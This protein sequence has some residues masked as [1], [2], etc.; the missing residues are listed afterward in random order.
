MK[1]TI[2]VATV[3]L[4]GSFALSCLAG[5]DPAP[6]LNKPDAKKPIFD[7]NA[8]AKADIKAAL[9]VA[10][11]D[12]RRVLIQWG[13][14]GCGLCL[15]LEECF[16]TDP[17]LKK[18]LLYEYVIVRVDVGGLGNKNADV[19]HHYKVPSSVPSLTVLDQVRGRKGGLRNQE[20][21][22]IPERSG[23]RAAQGRR[24]LGRRFGASGQDR[25]VC[26]SA[27]RR[28]MVRLVPEVGRLARS[29]ENRRDHRERLRGRED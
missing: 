18:V 7:E 25:A 3:L 23:G 29:A 11:R 1:T 8:D 15:Q 27:F 13:H 22:G 10:K 14:N 19:Y 17:G 21:A 16:R 24:G 20:T 12:N 5:D 9:H 28:P 26:V 4:A 6:R 2:C